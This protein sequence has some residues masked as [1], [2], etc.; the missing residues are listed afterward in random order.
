MDAVSKRGTGDKLS[1][2]FQ[3]AGELL[4]LLYQTIYWCR[5]APSS[6]DKIA[7]QMLIVGNATLPIA[8]ILA[9]FTGGVLALQTGSRLA[10]FGAEGSLGGLVGL[11]MVKELGPM[12]ISLLVAGRVGSAMAAE[13]GAMNVYDEIDALKTLE[14]DPVKFLVMPRFVASL[15]AVPALG[16][17]TT[18][19]GWI[20]GGLV[21]KYN[22]SIR[23]DFSPY[24]TNLFDTIEFTDIVHGLIKSAV[25]GVIIAIVSCYQG[26]RTVG[27][28]QEIAGSTT[29]A[30]VL[31]FVL[32][33][34]SNYFIS[35]LLV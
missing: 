31:S 32:I 4:N 16:I 11:A 9:L 14:I 25:F 10:E 30:V 24:F 35:R 26:F 21:A 7:R 34:I 27:G 1:Y 12:L 8:A 3:V 13:V 28:P 33:F 20:G 29:R 19:V 22:A 2:F 23:V 18:V 5:F 17:Y 6:R 15:I